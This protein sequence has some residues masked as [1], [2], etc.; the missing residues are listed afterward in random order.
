MSYPTSH[1]YTLLRFLPIEIDELEVEDRDL[2]VD[3]SFSLYRLT[4]SDLMRLEEYK[5]R[6]SRRAVQ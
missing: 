5:P 1:E 2:D 4:S 3:E 6:L